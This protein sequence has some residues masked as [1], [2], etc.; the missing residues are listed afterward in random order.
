MACTASPK[1]GT[2]LEVH[3]LGFKKFSEVPGLAYAIAVAPQ[4]RASTRVAEGRIDGIAVGAALGRDEGR[5]DGCVGACVG[6]ADGSEGAREVDG[7][8]VGKWRITV[9]PGEGNAHRPAAS[10]SSVSRTTRRPPFRTRTVA[11][12]TAP[13]LCAVETTTLETIASSS[14]SVHVNDA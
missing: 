4:A 6:P 10:T 13:V 3:V 11:E 12:P 9:G 8:T 2:A 7:I 14:K 5:A 1:P